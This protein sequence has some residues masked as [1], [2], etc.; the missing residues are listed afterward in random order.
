MYI[1]PP[2]AVPILLAV[3]I[4]LA[5]SF[6]PAQKV[7][8]RITVNISEETYERIVHWSKVNARPDG[9]AMKQ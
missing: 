4:A 9:K 7:P 3:G 1:S 5:A 6:A 8:S 2:V